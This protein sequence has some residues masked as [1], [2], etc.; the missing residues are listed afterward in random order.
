MANKG[1]RVYMVEHKETGEVYIGCTKETVNKR[2]TR[3]IWNANNYSPRNGGSTLLNVIRRE[4]VTN[5]EEFKEVFNLVILKDHI[6]TQED[7]LFFENSY[8]SFYD[9]VQDD[10]IVLNKKKPEKNY[11]MIAMLGGNA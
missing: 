8:I 5:K 10:A 7:A 11:W 6:E 1:Y 4:N 3:H 2:I 9:E